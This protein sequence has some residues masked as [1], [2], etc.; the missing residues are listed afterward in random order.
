MKYEFIAKCGE[1]TEQ[2]KDNLKAINYNQIKTLFRKK[3][4][5]VDGVRVSN[6]IFLNGGEKVEIFR[7]NKSKKKVE[8]IF[9]DENVIVAVKPQGMET[10]IKDKTYLESESLEDCF[11]NAKA[12]HRLDKNTEGLVVLAKNQMSEKELIR[13]FRQ[14]EIKKYYIALTYGKFNK[15]EDFLTNY[16]IKKDNKTIILKKEEKDCLIMKT[17]YKVLKEENNISMLLIELHTGI[18][19]QIRAVLSSLGHF[20]LGDD[21]YGNKK[22]NR[23][24]KIKKQCLCATKLEFNVNNN[25][26][27]SYLNNV[28]LQI[29]PTFID[30]YIK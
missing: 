29:K 22:I 26:F 4:I 7:P 11:N 3:D 15:K 9:E 1:L 30:K 20:V 23:E 14:R 13:I 25:S 24:F 18:T 8:T 27:L 12:V 10:T 2:I 17:Y 28:K 6:A 19:H 21:K 16:A 5:K